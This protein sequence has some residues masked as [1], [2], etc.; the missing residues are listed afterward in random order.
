MNS[1]AFFF[2]VIFYKT[3]LQV[4][5]FFRFSHLSFFSFLRSTS[6]SGRLPARRPLQQTKPLPDV[7]GSRRGAVLE[8]ELFACGEAL[9]LEEALLVTCF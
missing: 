3:M 7:Q 9:E 8:Q 4:L 2:V 1:N 6:T 5:Q